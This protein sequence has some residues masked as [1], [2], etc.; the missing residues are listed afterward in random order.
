MIHRLYMICFIMLGS[1]APVGAVQP[2]QSS[3]GVQYAVIIAGI[4]GEPQYVDQNWQWS[5]G[6]YEVLKEEHKFTE[7]QLFL[8]VENP[9]MDPAI[10]ARKSTLEEIQNTFDLL[11][12][13]MQSEDDLFIILIGHGSATGRGAKLNI[14][15]PDLSASAL[16]TLLDK[17][18]S[19]YLVIVNG[20]S[21]SAPFINALSGPN[22]AI[23]TATK[24][25][26]ERLATVFSAHFMA[27]LSMVNSDLDKDGQVSLL[28]TF[29]YTRL[30]TAEWYE[31]QGRL[32]TEHPLL[33]D[34]GDQSGSREAGDKA[35][36]GALAR[37]IRFGRQAPIAIQSEGT[38]E[39]IALRKKIETLQEQI[40]TLRWEKDAL[41]PETY[42]ERLEVLLI[43]LAQANR[44][45]KAIQ[46]EP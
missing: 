34:N 12:Q 17:V 20:A 23:I 8:L 11:G 40:N 37:R 46:E 1:N 14:S 29:N 38:G 33:D 27:A 31:E 41:T 4:G 19:R 16:N 22:R 9:D 45:R 25:G 3:A 15:G 10:P 5:S 36:D 44:E 28:E 39:A 18:K 2:L 24:S 42:S 13:R 32:A 7:N 35:P 26:G 21:S 6:I 43:Q 30:K